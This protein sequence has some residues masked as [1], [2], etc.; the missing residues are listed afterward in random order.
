[1]VHFVQGPEVEPIEMPETSQFLPTWMTPEF[2]YRINYGPITDKD[3]DKVAS[4]LYDQYYGI[5]GRLRRKTMSSVCRRSWSSILP[6]PW[7]RA[8]IRN[9][10]PCPDEDDRLR[11]RY[12]LEKEDWSNVPPARPPA[13]I[14]FLD[15]LLSDHI[16]H[17]LLPNCSF[18]NPYCNFRYRE[19]DWAIDRDALELEVRLC[20]MDTVLL[21]FA[22][23]VRDIRKLVSRLDS[24]WIEKDGT[25][26]L[27]VPELQ[28]MQNLSEFYIYSCPRA[29]HPR[30]ESIPRMKLGR[31]IQGLGTSD[32]LEIILFD[33]RRPGPS[34]QSLSPGPEL[35]RWIH[36]F[37]DRLFGMR[38]YVKQDEQSLSGLLKKCD[39]LTLDISSIDASFISTGPFRLM[40][41]TRFEDHFLLDKEGYLHVY[42]DFEP[43]D[44]DFESG[45]KHHFIWGRQGYISGS[46]G[47]NSNREE[48]AKLRQEV[49]WSRAI[50]FNRNA[51]SR[52]LGE[53]FYGVPMKIVGISRLAGE[54]I[55]SNME[56]VSIMCIYPELEVDVDN[57]PTATILEKFPYLA[58]RMVHL[59]E[60][61]ENWS[62]RTF[63][64]L[65]IP[66]YTNR[67]NW[68]V[69][70]F[71]LFFGVMS[72]MS[73][74]LS[75]YQAVV[76]QRQLAVAL[77]AFALQLNST[78]P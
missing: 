7:G 74:G 57:V 19:L 24:N 66:S 36:R 61:M 1:M 33:R 71:G 12:K 68:W 20:H 32:I 72:V 35:G 17:S 59:L 56:P 21:P 4:F 18:I 41:T 70:M 64:E 10:V 39:A 44:L 25:A 11:L 43:L 55:Q 8:A 37:G 65:F 15:P 77:Q 54:T 22:A 23:V 34:L 53:H 69:A 46:S 75:T 58:P 2:L 45:L 31:A 9:V 76:G 52:K 67:N 16:F 29:V 78:A 40:F 47:A 30:L 63:R 5:V 60:R 13:Y 26:I 50:L 27:E 14:G 51:A 42:W 38:E 49:Q 48:Y 62:P 6:S 3:R 73:M 28:E